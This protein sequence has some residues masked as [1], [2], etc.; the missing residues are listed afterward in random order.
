MPT[1]TKTEAPERV[2]PGDPNGH[3]WEGVA[4][5]R[6]DRQPAP[7]CRNDGCDVRYVDPRPKPL[8]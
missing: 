6:L 7:V 8:G 4:A 2:C 3:V 5:A 1:D